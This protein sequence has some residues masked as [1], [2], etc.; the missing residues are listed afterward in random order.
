MA[1]RTGDAARWPRRV[2]GSQDTVQRVVVG[3]RFERARVETF[4]SYP[5]DPR[6]DEKLV[7][8]VAC[9]LNPA[10]QAIVLCETRVSVQALDRTQASMR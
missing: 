10:G 7:T 2:R 4:S 9:K 5:T 8:C 1:R 3:T 6:F